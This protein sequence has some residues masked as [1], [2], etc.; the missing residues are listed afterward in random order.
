MGF[1]DSMGLDDVDGS[2]IDY[3]IAN[4][5]YPMTISDSKIIPHSKKPGIEQWQITYKVDGEVEDFGGRTVSE[6]FDL[7]PSLPD[8]RKAWLKRRLYSLGFDDETIRTMDPADVIGVDV[9]VTVVNKPAA[10]GSRTYTNVK[11][12]ALGNDADSYAA[13]N[14]FGNF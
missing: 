14:P 11:A 7:D 2:A 4:G 6:F 12:V 8:N 1:L 9:T 3:S 5:V 13:A 10:D